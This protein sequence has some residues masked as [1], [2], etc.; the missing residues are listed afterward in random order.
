MVYFESES[1]RLKGEMF[2]EKNTGQLVYLEWTKNMSPC[3]RCYGNKYSIRLSLRDPSGLIESKLKEFAAGESEIARLHQSYN[4]VVP[5]EHHR[6]HSMSYNIDHRGYIVEQNGYFGW[7]NEHG[8][9]ILPPSHDMVEPAAGQL[10]YRANGGNICLIDSTNR[11]LMDS[12]DENLSGWGPQ[13]SVQ[14]VMRKGKWLIINQQGEIENTYPKSS[15]AS[16]SGP[17]ANGTIKVRSHQGK[18]GLIRGNRVIIPVEFTYFDLYAGKGLISGYKDSM[19]YLFDVEG[20]VQFSRKGGEI[21]RFVGNYYPI[22][23]EGLFNWKTQKF[24]F[25]GKDFTNLA[26]LRD[27]FFILNNTEDFS[28]L[29]FDSIGHFIGKFKDIIIADESGV[30][31]ASNIQ[32]ERFGILDFEGKWLVQPIY[33]RISELEKEIFLGESQVWNDSRSILGLFR[34]NGE[35]ILPLKFDRIFSLGSGKYYIEDS[36]QKGIFTLADSSFTALPENLLFLDVKHY[37]EEIFLVVKKGDKTGLLD[38]NCKEVVPFE[39]SKIG[40]ITRYGVVV[41]AHGKVGVIKR[42]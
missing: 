38:I 10:M 5:M 8:G 27:K 23:G 9:T 41:E 26:D 35:T 14:P 1:F 29:L 21:G 37:E 13:Y 25:T 16:L 36:I 22:S 15:Y 12:L 40:N 28:K 7:L 2:L 34:V 19:A 6:I 20:N 3:P 11:V 30:M 24:I 31:I 42:S 17:E 4:W 33:K 39:F 32:T 18:Y